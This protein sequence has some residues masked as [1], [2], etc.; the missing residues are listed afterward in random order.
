M[1][2]YPRESVGGTSAEGELC[3]DDSDDDSDDDSEES[4]GGSDVAGY[5]ADDAANAWDE[6]S[7]TPARVY[8]PEDFNFVQESWVSDDMDLDD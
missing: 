6:G 5:T 2:L 7:S 8:G 3:S 4:S 1:P